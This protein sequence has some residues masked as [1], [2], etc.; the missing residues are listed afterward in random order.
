MEKYKVVHSRVGLVVDPVIQNVGR[1]EFEDELRVAEL[2]T[3]TSNTL[4]IF[5]KQRLYATDF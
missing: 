1:L 5:Y 2:R 4:S 3:P